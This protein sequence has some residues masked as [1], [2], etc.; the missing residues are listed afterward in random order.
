MALA[1]LMV[2][3]LAF[4]LLLAPHLVPRSALSPGSGIA[5]L[6]SLLALRAAIVVSVA[7]VAVAALPSTGPFSALSGWSFHAVLPFVSAHFG[8]NGHAVAHLAVLI[9]ASVVI[10]MLMSAGLAAWRATR[11]VRGWIRSSSVGSGPGG[12]LIVGGSEVV[13]ATVGLRSPQILIS[14]GALMTLDDGELN[15]GLEH[16][17]GHVRRGHRFV[18]LLAA[19]L[20]GCS[21]I[22][23]GGRS[24]LRHLAFHLERDADEYAL[25]RT[26]D[27]RSLATAIVK[28]ATPR[29]GPTALNRADHPVVADRI[30][31]LQVGGVAS[32]PIRA[33]VALL[34]GLFIAAVAGILLVTPLVVATNAPDS[35]APFGS[36]FGC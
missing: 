8:L 24:V 3:G 20:D 34:T 23:P 17:W 31:A 13:L 12:S 5:L 19:V 25:R 16:E 30:H 33:L 21:S 1:L 7:L 18:S 2:A 10:T 22:L 15:A 28:A 6:M 35:V 27:R 14:A 32:F 29:R 4:G 11:E 9:P 26:N 36:L